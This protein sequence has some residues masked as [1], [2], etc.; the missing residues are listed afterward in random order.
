MLAVNSIVTFVILL[1]QNIV[2][3]F[4]CSFAYFS[5]PL[6]IYIALDTCATRV[7]D[8]IMLG[9]GNYTQALKAILS[10]AS[11]V[12]NGLFQLNNLSSENVSRSPIIVWV[13]IGILLI[14]I[15]YFLY[16]KMNN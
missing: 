8:K 5:L 3:S 6:V 9:T 14:V 12:Y 2:D 13:I 1:T 11:P 15:N 10:Y 4:I 16:S 7:V